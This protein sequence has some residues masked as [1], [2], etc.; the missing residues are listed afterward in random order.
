MGDLG[1]ALVEHQE[2]LEVRELAAI[3]QVVEDVHTSGPQDERDVAATGL[4]E[5]VLNA[6]DRMP[7]AMARVMAFAGAESRA[8]CRAWND[9]C[10]M[11]TKPHRQ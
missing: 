3:F 7:A 8:Y 2:G 11:E 6:G 4:L 1:R 10:G 5:A 9:F